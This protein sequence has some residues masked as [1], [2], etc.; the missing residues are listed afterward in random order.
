VASGSRFG[1]RS[2]ED[3][4]ERS[5]SSP[6]AGSRQRP[7]LDQRRLGRRDLETRAC[8]LPA[9]ESAQILPASPALHPEGPGAS[10]KCSPNNVGRP[11]VNCTRR[12]GI[13]TWAR[14][15]FC[16]NWPVRVPALRGGYCSGLPTF[17]PSLLSH[18]SLS[19]SAV[20][21]RTNVRQ[22][23]L[24]KSDRRDLPDRR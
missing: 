12:P 17:S 15:Q 5:G 18:L 24:R 19:E 6:C 16:V 22:I 23:A 13:H 20:P 9:N 8:R 1:S 4:I 14:T 10:R 3:F 11:L 21:L 7:P 2:D